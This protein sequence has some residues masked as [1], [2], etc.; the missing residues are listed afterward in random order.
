MGFS[1]PP[2]SFHDRTFESKYQII[3]GMAET[4]RESSL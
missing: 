1:K 4:E 3:L 2:S